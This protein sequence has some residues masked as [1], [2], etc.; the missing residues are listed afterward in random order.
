MPYTIKIGHYQRDNSRWIIETHTD[1][2]GEFATARYLGRD[3]WDYDAIATA[4]NIKLLESS[5]DNEAEQAVE[6][7]AMPAMRFQ[8]ATQFVD[9]V[10]AMYLE[11]DGEALARV[12]VWMRNRIQAADITEAQ[13]QT[14]FGMDAGQW[15]TFKTTMQGLAGA[16]DEVNSAAGA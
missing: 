8:N 1:G 15:T 9:R 10:R 3:G 6:A 13:F 2:Q 14:A 16:Y 4:R 11:R 5:A 12:A 7:D